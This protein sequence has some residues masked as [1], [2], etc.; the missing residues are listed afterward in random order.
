MLD[1]EVIHKSRFRR[2][3]GK[4]EKELAII[5]G[6]KKQKISGKHRYVYLL[7]KK[8]SLNYSILPYP[9]H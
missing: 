5:A 6:A 2:R 3:D 1:G 4:S 8:I 7:N 9:K